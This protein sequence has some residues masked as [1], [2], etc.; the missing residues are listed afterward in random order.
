MTAKDDRRWRSR[1]IFNAG[2]RT[3][4]EWRRRTPRWGRGWGGAAENLFSTSIFRGKH[5]NGGNFVASRQICMRVLWPPP[6][7]AHSYIYRAIAIAPA[8]LN[9][10]YCTWNSTNNSLNSTNYPL[11]AKGPASSA[12][13]VP[14]DGF[15]CIHF[16]ERQH[17][18]LHNYS[19]LWCPSLSHL[20]SNCSC[21]YDL[22]IYAINIYLLQF[23]KLI[24]FT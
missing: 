18:L 20:S 12:L 1:W 24:Q 10:R 13:F 21:M 2:S 14:P 11:H 23:I 6:M 15:I 9:N 4:R 16:S 8:K 19:R 5:W 17:L 22:S 3:P 7:V